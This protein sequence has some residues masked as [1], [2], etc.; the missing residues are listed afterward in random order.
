VKLSTVRGV[1]RGLIRACLG[2]RNEVVLHALY[3]RVL[4]RTGRFIVPES[5]STV[6][7]LEVASQNAR[8]VLDI[9]ANAGR[10]S[11]FF[12]RNARKGVTIYAF[13]PMPTAFALLQANVAS[14]SS[15]TCLPLALADVD[16]REVLH[17]PLDSFGN[18]ASGYSWI[19]STEGRENELTVQ[20]SVTSVDQL[21]RNRRLLL[22]R[23]LF[24]KI[25]VEGSEYRVLRGARETLRIYRPV[26]YFECQSWALE[27]VGAKVQSVNDLLSAAN[28]ETWAEA[29]G[30]F[31]NYDNIDPGVANFFAIPKVQSTQKAARMSAEEF[32]ILLRRALED[33]ERAEDFGNAL[34]TGSAP[35]R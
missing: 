12:A 14:M 11:W 26:I 19:S 1:A 20:V 8:T 31:T 29:N 32:V 2:E 23:P 16:G 35:G 13:E 10:Y 28:Y 30:L 17:V 4:R 3:H 18:A 27:R 22:D 15:V 7:A 9:G 34:G 25:D 33:D 5:P 24:L 6:R 21:V